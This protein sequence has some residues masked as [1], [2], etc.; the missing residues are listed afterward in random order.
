LQRR[1]ITVSSGEIVDQVLC[2]NSGML[3][4]MARLG[5]LVRQAAVVP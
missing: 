3:K 1:E 5:S 2:K 4:L